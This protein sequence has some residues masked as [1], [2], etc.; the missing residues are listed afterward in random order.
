M[1]LCSFP[2]PSGS[3]PPVYYSLL[4][5]CEE[6]GNTQVDK[7]QMPRL[8][9]VLQG[10]AH[11]PSPRGGTHSRLP[12]TSAIMHWLMGYGLGTTLSLG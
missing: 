4:V 3:S 5:R 9:L 2:S 12:I 1:S 10:V 11:S 7:G 8:Q 6:F